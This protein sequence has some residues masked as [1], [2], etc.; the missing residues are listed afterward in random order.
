MFALKMADNHY[1]T[2]L[3]QTLETQSMANSLKWNPSVGGQ[4]EGSGRPR[5]YMPVKSRVER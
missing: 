1:H 3:A 5:L 2:Q 4:R